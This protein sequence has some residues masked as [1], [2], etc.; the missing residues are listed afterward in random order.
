MSNEALTKIGEKILLKGWVNRRRDMGNV[1]FIDLRDKSGIIQVVLVL[2]NLDGESKSAAE[3]LRPEFVISVEGIVNNRGEAQINKEIETGTIEV[4]A[5]NLVI[6]NEAKTTPFEIDKDT[7]QINEEIR[8]TY[9]YLDLRTERMKKN[10]IGR[11]KIVKAVREYLDKNNFTE[12]ETPILIKG[13]P[14]G[15]REFLV[16]SRVHAGKFYVLPQSPQQLKQLL[17][18]GG[19]ER[20]YQIARCFRDEDQRGDRQ[21][22]FTQIDMEMAFMSQDEILNLVEGMMIEVCEKIRP[23]KQMIFKPFKRLTYQEAMNGYGS[24]KPEL[25]FEMP[26]T[27]I[28]EEVKGCGFAI[29]ADAVAKGGMV[30]ALRAEGGAK[31]SRKELDELTEIAKKK[32]AKGLVSMIL[33]DKKID[34]SVVK[35][36]GDDLTEK[37]IDKTGAIDGDAIFIT[38]DQFET[39]CESLGQVRLEIGKRFNLLDQNKLAF[40]WVVDFPMFKGNK[41]GEEHGYGE[42][43]AMHHPFTRPLDEDK[44]L[45]DSDPL[46]ARANAYDLVLN[47][48]EVGGGSVRIHERDLQAKI[49][50]LLKITKEEAEKRFGHLLRAFEY[51]APPHGG[52]APGLDRLVMILM[53]EPNIREVIAFPKTGDAR[54]LMLSAPSDLPQEK[55]DEVHIEVKK[56]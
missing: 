36:L 30:K 37:I 51:G 49:F 46:S 48:Y 19:M 9:R 1:A 10:I 13:T 32:G 16:P 27:D 11:H 17:M 52:I 24:D 18:V 47:G 6:L 42:I 39:A 14:E 26:F 23:D 21:P 5:E 25:R 12:I 8:L 33:K 28:S 56:D 38:A 20:Y 15:A 29:F 22:E 53:D 44:H 45:L 2:N 41:E 31:F 54:D 35:H 3:K 4:L 7:S 50:D 34:S 43:A 55:L 40:L